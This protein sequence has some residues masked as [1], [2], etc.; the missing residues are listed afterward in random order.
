MIFHKHDITNKQKMKVEDK[1]S[2]KIKLIED[3]LEIHSAPVLEN[4]SMGFVS[5]VLAQATLPYRDLEISNNRVYSRT[6]GNVTLQVIP[7]S[8]KYGVPFGIIPRLV[9]AWICTETIK[10]KDRT[11]FL[12]SSQNDFLRKLGLP[13]R[14][15]YVL[16][17][18]KEQSMRLFRALI[19]IEY[20]S[21]DQDNKRKIEAGIRVLFTE[22]D[23]VFWQPFSTEDK[24]WE[25]R[26]V[27]SEEFFSHIH[28]H[29][30]PVDL[31]V[32]YALKGSPLAMDIYTWLTY[33][34]YLLVKSEYRQVQISW[35]GLRKQFGSGIREDA[36][37][38]RK[39]KSEFL[40]RLKEVLHFYPEAEGHVEDAGKYL[41]LTPCSLHIPVST[42][43]STAIKRSFANAKKKE[44]EEESRVEES[45]VPKG[46][47]E[48]V[49]DIKNWVKK[50]HE[51]RVYAIFKADILSTNSLVL[52]LMNFPP[53]YIKE[54]F[55]EFLKTDL[56][57]K[58]SEKNKSPRGCFYDFLDS[59]Y[60]GFFDAEDKKMKTKTQEKQHQEKQCEQKK[61]EEI[62]R[63][64]N[65][66]K[67]YIKRF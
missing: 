45:R 53:D 29:P 56:L 13:I 21:I 11:L 23:L 43:N 22:K 61:E 58:C 28:E 41:K 19:T 38:I 6:T 32:Y 67:L 64:L 25:S 51:D 47:E 50:T 14:N 36:A 54:K 52:Y 48:A 49:L 62:V 15:G 44:K 57:S 3:A 12:G 5:R 60:S 55:S 39:F 37:G 1:N 17:R 4:H 33:R 9:L 7:T 18:L 46:Y 65:I 8:E 40:K 30:V 31:R 66:E 42:K 59:S 63:Q 16:A 27:L 10:T 20:A 24:P 26:I 34:M 2:R 35:S